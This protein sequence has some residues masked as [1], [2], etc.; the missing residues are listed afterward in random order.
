MATEIFTW[1][2]GEGLRLAFSKIDVLECQG[3]RLETLKRNMED[4]FSGL[5]PFSVYLAQK[6]R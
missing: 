6:V 2:L 3:E 1:G 4:C 5:F